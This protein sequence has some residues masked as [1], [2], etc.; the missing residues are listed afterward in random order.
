MSSAT[1]AISAHVRWRLRH[2]VLGSAMLALGFGAPAVAAESEAAGPEAADTAQGS[3]GQLEEIVVTAQKREESLQ[4]VPL[5]VATLSSSELERRDITS[6]GDLMGGQVPSLRIEPFAGNPTVLEVAIRGFIDPNGVNVTNENPVPIYIDDVFY[7]RQTATSLQLNE[8]DRIEVLRGPQGTLFGKNAEGGAVRIISKE[9]TGEFDIREKVEGGNFGYW[10]TTTHMDLPSVAGVATKIDFLDTGNSGW[11]TNPAPGEENFGMLRSIG[12]RFTALWRPTDLLRIEYAY[13]WTQIKS[14]EVFNQLLATNDVYQNTFGANGPN[15]SVWPIQTTR[16]TTIP[17]PTYRPFDPQKFYGHRIT[18]SWDLG[19]NTLLKS[20]TAYRNDNSVLWN[21]ASTTAALPG[22]FVGAP[23]LGYITAP[24]PVYAIQ[25]SQISEELQLAGSTNTLQWVGGLF[26]LGEHG[27]QL[28]TTYFGTSF[29]NAILSGPPGFVPV[30]LG[31]A[32]ALDPPFNA[33]G[34]TGANISQQ[35]YA[36]YS[37][38]TWRPDVLEDKFSYTVGLRVGRDQKDDSRPVGG[39]YN[40]V[41]YPVPPSTTPPPPD[42]VCTATPRPAQ[43][44]ATD[45]RTKA[46]PLAS[47]AYDWT[48]DVRSYFRYSTG[49]QAAVIG[50]AAQT[51][52]FTAPSSVNSFELGT[53]SEFFD[54]RARLNVALFYLDRKDPQENIQ[55]VSSSTVEYFTGGDIK[56][57]GAEFD[58]AFE[59]MS[60][61]TISVAGTYLHGKQDPTLDPFTNPYAGGG[62]VPFTAQLAQT[63]KFAGSV[64]VLY[65]IARMS[66]GAIW[67]LDADASTTTSYYSVPNVSIPIAGYTLFNG[68]FSLAQIPINGGKFGKLDVSLWGKNLF[69]KDYR[70]FTYAAPAVAALNPSLPAVNTASSFGEPRTYGVS[71]LFKY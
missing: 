2:A 48:S 67:R 44:S 10:N 54:R 17:Y 6:L 4:S 60:G 35:S 51:F 1:R 65:D 29:P 71:V 12:A 30:S 23:Q 8:I 52:K 58:A 66:S 32:V 28:E 37:Q 45:A 3:S 20:I 31:N 70:T 15:G 53:K 34:A 22:L 16:D 11:Q 41:T 63:P 24:A 5:S 69:N 7:G 21:T 43:C 57:F 55:T 39:V 56:I 68:R 36:A 47:I 64:S 50:L 25:H 49:Y 40:N 61:L 14:T 33:G 9:P 46:L 62:A 38:V 13:D 18:A 59:P 27:S 19:N 42:Y 26:F